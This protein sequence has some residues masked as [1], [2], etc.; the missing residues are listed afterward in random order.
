MTIGD[1]NTQVYYCKFDDQDEL[2]AC[3]YGDGMTR[4]YDTNSGKLAYTLADMK[5]TSSMPI[6]CL[7]W[8][9]TS[10]SLKTSNIIVTA[11]ADG[12]LTHWH[13][14]SGKMLHQI[15]PDPENHIY[16]MDFSKDGTLLA[17]AGRDLHVHIYDETTKQLAFTMKEGPQE[18]GHSNRIFCCKFNKENPN[19]V[20][21][22]GWDNTV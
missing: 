2:L 17:V 7:Q 16:T 19:M 1:G 20:V 21:S 3:G 18:C 11:S 10:S 22:G 8:R 13:A 12:T 4:I 5:T 15:Q 9:P 14:T 6:T